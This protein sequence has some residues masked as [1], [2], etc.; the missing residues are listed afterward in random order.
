MSNIPKARKIINDVL[1]GHELHP[2]VVSDLHDALDL[3]TRKVGK[4]Q[5]P[6]KSAPMTAEM[7]QKVRTYAR[8][9]PT[10]TQ[11]E[12]ARLFCVNPGRVSE[13]LKGN[14]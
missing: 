9:H 12:I 11:A 8:I 13:A 1:E 2:M 4:R 10:K 5:A 6:A 3:M 14:R 7:A